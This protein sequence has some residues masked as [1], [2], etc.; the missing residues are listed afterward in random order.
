MK[1][2]AFRLFG[3]AVVCCIVT[4][5]GVARGVGEACAQ[6]EG[7]AVGSSARVERGGSA[8]RMMLLGRVEREATARGMAM[9][10]VANP[11]DEQL[12]YIMEHFQALPPLAQGLDPR[13]FSTSPVWTGNGSQGSSGRAA[14]ANLSFSFP[15]DGPLWGSPANTP[16]NLSATFTTVFGTGNIDKG[17]EY[18]RQALASWRR[19][20]GLTY[21]EVADNNSAMDGSTTHTTTRGDIRIGCIPQGTSSGVLAYNLFPNNGGDTTLNSDQFGTGAMGGSGSNYRYLRNVVSHEHGHGLG[22]YHAVPCDGTKLME[23]FANTSFDGTQVDEIR[24]AG[25]NYGDKYAGNNSGAAAKDFGN[26]TTPVLRSVIER[27]LS[28]N[29]ASG[30]NATGEDW[31]KFTINSTQNVTITATAT[32]GTYTEGQQSSGCTGTTASVV[33]TQAGNLAVELRN[34]TNGATIVQSASS[35]AAGSP[36]TVTANALAAGTYWVRIVDQGPNAATNQVVQLY[37]LLVRVGT[38]K[39]TPYA[40]AG[41]HKRVQAGTNCFFMGNINSYA[42]DGAGITG[43]EWDL[44]GDGVFGGTFDSAAAQPIKQYVSNGTYPITLRVTDSNAMKGTDTINLVVFGATAA[45]NAVSPNLALPSQVVPV[46]ITGVNF[47]GIT[48]AS[49]VTVS[50]TSVIVTG[51]PVVNALGTQITGLVFNVSAGAAGGAFNISV[52]NSDGSGSASGNATGVGLFQINANCVAPAITLNPVSA[53]ACAGG[54]VTFTVGAS[55]TAPSYQWR[56]SAVPIPGAT[57]TSLT[58]SSVGASDVANYDCIASNGCGSATSGAASLTL[59]S[60]NILTQ[61]TPSTTVCQGAT[62]T[63]TIVT[64]DIANYQWEKDG[65]FLDGETDPTITIP[66]VTLDDA[67]GYTCLVI[68][69]C[70]QLTSNTANLTVRAPAS[71]TQQPVPAAVCEGSPASFS[72]LATGAGRTYQWRKNG[73]PI[74]GATAASLSFLTTTAADAANYDCVVNGT[75][76]GETS[77]TVSLGVCSPVSIS[78]HPANAQS[79][80]GGSAMFTVGGSGTFLNYQWYKGITPIAGATGSSLTI[81]PVGASAAGS[82]TCVVSNCCQSATSNAASLSVC[83]AD[84]NC[85]GGLTV[86][87]IFDF[88]SAWF[89]GSPAA[90][91][92]GV[93][94]LSV[95]DIFDFLSGWFAGC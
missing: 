74:S 13:F 28:T 84:F 90:D 85:S 55:G 3:P 80:P 14:K 78:S 31:F 58:I 72:L 18:I 49:Q 20:D 32:G 81:N 67:G 46:T 62:V 94:G 61:P 91:Y 69:P 77:T 59:G 39:A 54:S 34:G 51:T 12:A 87:D 22:Y 29:G 73:N 76:G 95:Q 86:Q 9:C 79:C 35:A 7:S 89:S 71:I 16:N 37:D 64:S 17:R 47:R 21:T 48:S 43:Y 10:F 4:I 63:F 11:T 41:V 26:L 8:S 82:Y 66:N 45:V 38:A 56:K 88:L 44:D 36:E 40:I 25:S 2:C 19:F 33:A 93:G 30:V 65:V 53:G 68:T 52:T 83:A 23:P 57:S 27:S 92:N 50:G 60:V 24:G 70:R 75:C 6:P 15:S 42:V 5:C 1:F